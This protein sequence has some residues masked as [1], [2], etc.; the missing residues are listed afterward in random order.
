MI[1]FK[2]KFE[3]KERREGDKIESKAKIIG[4]DGPLLFFA[5][6]MMIGEKRGRSTRQYP[7]PEISLR[8]D[9]FIAYVHTRPDNSGCMAGQINE[10]LFEG[11]SV[12][13]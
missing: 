6:R 8:P 13:A 3:T 7:T 4:F 10:I 11:V 12:G 5:F 2:E 1:S 9:K